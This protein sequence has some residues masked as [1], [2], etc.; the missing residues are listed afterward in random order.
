M[1]T[2]SL[3]GALNNA[4]I[5]AGYAANVQSQRIVGNEQVCYNWNGFDSVGRA[6][7]APSFYTKSA[8][9]NQAIDRIAVENNIVRPQYSE[10]AALNLSG[11]LGYPQTAN[12]YTAPGVALQSRSI[13]NVEKITGRP[14]V[15]YNFLMA[16]AGP[17]LAYSMGTMQS[18]NRQGDYGMQGYA[19]AK[20]N[21][22]VG[23][24]NY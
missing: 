12:A 22:L 11:L 21:Q 14:G 17:T 8:G 20:L 19:Q 18:A 5:D 9:C 23:Q 6:V 10:Y 15:D 24:G 4:K 16:D 2:I 7:C 1:S 3:S 13:Q